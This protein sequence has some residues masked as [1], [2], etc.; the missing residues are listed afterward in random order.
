MGLL[1]RN[2]SGDLIELVDVVLELLSK[3]FNG[4]RRNIEV[5]GRRVGRVEALREDFR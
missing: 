5:L 4:G 1:G 3:T 2:R